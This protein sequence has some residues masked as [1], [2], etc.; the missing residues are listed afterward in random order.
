MA[1][2]AG[3]HGAVCSPHELPSL[4]GALPR[5]FFLV[6]PGIRGLGTVAADDQQR[7]STPEQALADGSDL[8]VIGRPLTAAKHPERSL[9][10]LAA[11]LRATGPGP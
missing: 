6:T 1:R 4:R 5:P 3:C 7:V 10:E 11:R 2:A 8:L 9:E